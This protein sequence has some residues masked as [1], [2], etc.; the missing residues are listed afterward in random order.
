MWI[1]RKLCK[2]NNNVDSVKV[3]EENNLN[4]MSPGHKSKSKDGVDVSHLTHRRWG[5]HNLM[6]SPHKYISVDLS[7]MLTTTN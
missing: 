3:V 5:S 6:K 2:S 4:A 1:P 7:E